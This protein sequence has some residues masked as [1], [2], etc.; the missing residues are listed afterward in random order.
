MAMHETPVG[1]LA[2]CH[3]SHPEVVWRSVLGNDVLQLDDQRQVAPDD[4]REDLVV[5]VVRVAGQCPAMRVTFA[6]T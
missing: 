5:V 6:S 2:A 1:A 4:L 3:V